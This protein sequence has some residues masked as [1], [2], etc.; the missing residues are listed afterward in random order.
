[1]SPR[2]REGTASGKRQ[3][4]GAVARAAVR[5]LRTVVYRLRSVLGEEVLETVPRGYRL[6]VD[7]AGVR[8]QHSAWARN[9]AQVLVDSEHMFV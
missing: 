4:G 7:V 2:L 3:F 6:V 9:S 8:N 5:S 1:V